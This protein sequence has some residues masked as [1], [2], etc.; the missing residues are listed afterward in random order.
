VRGSYTRRRAILGGERQGSGGDY[1]ALPAAPSP[2]GQPAIASSVFADGT[3]T[4]TISVSLSDRVGQ[5]SVLQ[6]QAAESAPV[7][8]TSPASAAD[9]RPECSARRGAGGLRRVRRCAGCRARIRVPDGWITKE[10][11]IVVTVRQRHTPKALD[12]AAI[13]A[14]RDRKSDRTGVMRDP[15]G[16]YKVLMHRPTNG[17]YRSVD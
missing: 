5:A 10:R 14:L 4:W 7:A 15:F 1:A 11:G 12:D 2:G 3:V 8:I 13:N 9:A 6:T 16:I 17:P